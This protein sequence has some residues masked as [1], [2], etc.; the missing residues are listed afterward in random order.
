MKLNQ[1]AFPHRCQEGVRRVRRGP[2]GGTDPA[3]VHWTS[4]PILGC[5][6]DLIEVIRVGGA[7]YE[8]VYVAWDRARLP[9]ISCGPRAIDERM[10]NTIYVGQKIVQHWQRPEGNGQ[11]VGQ[12]AAD[13]SVGH[14]PKQADISAAGVADEPCCDQT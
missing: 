6:R 8:D 5:S 7:D 14:G 12:R 11:Q 9:Q 3:D 1:W 10:R 4:E 13:R 2:G